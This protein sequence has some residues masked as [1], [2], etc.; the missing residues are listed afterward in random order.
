[1]ALRS[2]IIVF[3][4]LAVFIVRFVGIVLV[5]LPFDVLLVLAFIFI[6]VIMVDLLLAVAFRVV[7]VISIAF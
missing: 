7:I 5:I 1:M 3:V 6:A 2:R 4:I